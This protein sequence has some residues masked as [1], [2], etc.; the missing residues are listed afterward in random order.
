[1]ISVTVP[2]T[3]ATVVTVLVVIVAILVVVVAILVV[4]VATRMIVTILIVPATLIVAFTTRMI[5]AILI[6]PTT[7]LLTR[8]TLAFDLC[9]PFAFALFSSILILIPG[10]LCLGRRARYQSDTTK[11]QQ[12][13]ECPSKFFDTVDFHCLL[14][15]DYPRWQ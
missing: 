4:V 8:L 15:S 1:M 3:S 2:V 12:S 13:Q 11:Q 10:I 9:L 7:L 14:T 6:V 5:V